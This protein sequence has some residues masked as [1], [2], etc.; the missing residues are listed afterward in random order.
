MEIKE[1]KI[2]QYILASKNSR[3]L[4]FILDYVIINIITFII[5][6]FLDFIFYSN[7]TGINYWYNQMSRIEKYLFWA[8]ISFIY[9]TLTEILLSRSIAKYF[10]KTIVVTENGIKPKLVN[11]LAR[12]ALRLVPFESFTFLQGRELGLHDKNSKT[13]VVKTEKLNQILKTLDT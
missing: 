1:F 13:F 2:P 9:Y 7:K 11:I 10:T 8:L 5:I 3:L 6:Y 4:N 12:S